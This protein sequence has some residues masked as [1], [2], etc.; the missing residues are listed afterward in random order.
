VTLGVL[1]G[2]FVGKPIGIFAFAWISART[3]FTSLPA[4][5]TWWQILGASCL[6]GIGFTMS[7]FIAGLALGQGDALDM[8]KIAILGAS[9]ASGACG[10]IMLV[11]GAARRIESD[12]GEDS[13]RLPTS[14]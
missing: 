2:L 9:V 10:A 8:A 7:L 5:V 13:G 12:P 11:C 4:T 1:L 14:A 3:K 6:C